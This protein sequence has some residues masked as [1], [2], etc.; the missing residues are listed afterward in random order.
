MTLD[1]QAATSFLATH[2][3]MLD[4]RRFQ[5]LL[6]DGD[7]DGVL[8]ALDAYRNPD[9]GY[10]WGLEPDLRSP[11]SQPTAA[12]H[13]FEVLAELAPATTPHALELCD[14]LAEH[15]LADGGLP[16]ALPVSDPAGCA[17]W[18]AQADHATSS[19]QMTAQVAANA[20]VV[21]RHAPAVAQH[22]WLTTATDW[23]LEAIRAV[24]VAPH[25]YV[26]LFALRF[27][28]AAAD[29]VP[30]ARGLLEHLGRHVPADGSMHVVGGT[31][32][33]MLH[34][35][36]FAPDPGRPV[37]SL[38]APDDIAADL[39]RLAN[40]QQSDGGWVVDYASVSPAA[41]LEWRGYATVRAV[42]VLQSND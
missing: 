18:W 19:L 42:A 37:R 7:R 33:E 41:A 20:H 27:L 23:C 36:D 29:T 24:D 17:P 30:D 39:D 13:A 16:F 10:G 8:A 9:G 15:S 31:E 34:P 32:D 35:L 26:L 5:L 12:M 21:A 22:P 11:E 38:F 25:A 6:G 1:L 4:R 40:L 2:G 3:R 14:W 28:D